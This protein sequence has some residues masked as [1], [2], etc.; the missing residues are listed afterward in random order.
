MG[1]NFFDNEIVFRGYCELRD[2]D[3]NCNILMEQPEMAQLLP[4]LKGQCVLDLGCGFGHN[5]IEFIR[6]GAAHVTGIDISKKML[7]VAQREN[8]HPDIEYINM[9]MT[10][11]DRINGCFDLV[12]SSLAF[13]YIEDMPKLMADIARLLKKGGILLFSQE[14]PIYTASENGQGHYLFDELGNKSGFCFSH[15]QV[16]G[17]RTDEWFIKGRKYYHRRF[18]DIANAIAWAGLCIQNVAEP[19]PDE[20]MITKRPKSDAVHNPL[21][22]I[23]KAVKL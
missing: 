20:N 13:H 15:Y 7:T 21:F 8:S 14:H 10:D 16:P 23:I 2:S 12:Y 19:V 1:Q 17:E 6:R 22:L 18:S 11:I 9:S 4:E 3:S 5:C